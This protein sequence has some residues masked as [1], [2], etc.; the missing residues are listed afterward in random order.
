M[1][2]GRRATIVD[3]RS[4]T[5]ETAASIYRK[6]YWNTV[7]AD[8]LAAGVDALAFDIAVNSGPGRALQWLDESAHMNAVQRIGFLI[9]NAGRSI[10]GYR[11]L[12]RF[13]RGWMA[14][15]NDLQ[16][17]ALAMVEDAAKQS[18]EALA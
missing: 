5:V 16:S 15:E 10:V 14:R 9:K 7:N 1:N 18:S 4:M 17:H 2:S 8:A 12:W 6:K 13:G 3:V 11:L